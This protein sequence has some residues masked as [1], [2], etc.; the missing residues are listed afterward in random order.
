MIH[1]TMNIFFLINFEELAKYSIVP[2]IGVINLTPIKAGI[3]NLCLADKG[4]KIGIGLKY[5]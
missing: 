2:F 3:L 5:I 1:G 4:Q